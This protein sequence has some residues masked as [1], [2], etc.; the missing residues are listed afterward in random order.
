MVTGCTRKQGVDSN[1]NLLIEHKSH[2][3]YSEI[4]E[5]DNEIF[6]VATPYSVLY[7]SN[8][9][10]TMFIFSRQVREYC[11]VKYEMPSLS[12]KKGNDNSYQFHF[13]DLH[14]FCMEEEI[15]FQNEG[16]D[17]I[18][19]SMKNWERNDLDEFGIKVQYT[20][21]DSNMTI[22]PT[23]GGV[24]IIVDYNQEV[25]HVSFPIT[26]IECTR[27]NHKAGY[28]TI[29]NQQ[30]DLYIIHQAVAEYPQKIEYGLETNIQKKNSQWKLEVSLSDDADLT[31]RIRF[32]IDS[33]S[34]QMFFDSSVYESTPRVNNI[35]SN[36]SY[37]D[38]RS[39]LQNGCTYVKFN[40]RTI[41]PKD[42][43]AMEK[44][45]FSFYI[46]YI[47]KPVTLEF[48]GMTQDWC[49]WRITWRN[50]PSINNKLGECYIDQKGWYTVDLTGYIKNVIDSDYFL[51]VDNSFMIRVKDDSSGYVVM[52][53]TDH[54]SFFPYFEVNYSVK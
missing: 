20:T 5:R 46:E 31:K 26:L 6:E 13:N 12:F 47:E 44:F 19:I 17:A 16:K 24:E 36:Y 51:L 21:I 23:F 45:Y 27:K 50:K 43:G 49:S 54:S 9:K 15:V 28:V 42:S 7:K 11:D 1:E 29:E 22:L 32:M 14:V 8:K 39:G 33:V 2:I 18:I 40:A 35:Y 37:L 48:Y 41:T 34:E 30:K 10:R 25:N 38:N 3:D 52:A 53:S 4:L